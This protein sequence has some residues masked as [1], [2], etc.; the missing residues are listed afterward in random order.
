M[1]Y[2]LIISE[3]NRTIYQTAVK[4]KQEATLFSVSCQKHIYHTINVSLEEFR[5]VKTYP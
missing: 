1:V 4:C 3:N 5:R 2:T